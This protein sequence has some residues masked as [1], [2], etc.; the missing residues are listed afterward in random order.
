MLRTPDLTISLHVFRTELIAAQAI[1]KQKLTSLVKCESFI[2][3]QAIEK[4]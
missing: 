2:A 3:A 4:K 1:E